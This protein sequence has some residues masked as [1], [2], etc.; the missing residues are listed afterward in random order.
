MVCKR[1][2]LPLFFTV[3]FTVCFVELPREQTR[4]LPQSAIFTAKIIE[5]V[6]AK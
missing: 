1:A 3:F 5:N 6:I 2:K 4:F